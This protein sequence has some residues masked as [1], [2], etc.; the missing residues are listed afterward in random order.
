MTDCTFAT[1]GRLWTIPPFII[2]KKSE[3]AFYTFERWPL[4]TADI[5]DEVDN[6]AQ[7]SR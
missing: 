3:I 1:T 5:Y 2:R 6:N 4:G 7:H